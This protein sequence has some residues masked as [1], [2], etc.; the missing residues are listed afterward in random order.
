[1]SLTG[2]ALVWCRMRPIK[3][4]QIG[5]VG[6]LG[7]G[8][9]GNVG[10][11]MTKVCWLSM[12]LGLGALLV[13]CR[14]STSAPS[15]VG[16]SPVGAAASG[17]T[18]NVSGTV[19][20]HTVI[21]KRPLA[22]LH[23]TVGFVNRMQVDVVSD[24]NGH[25]EAAGFPDGISIFLRV[26]PEQG[27]RAPCPAPIVLLKSNTLLDLDVVSN[28]TLL[29]SGVPASLPTPN[30]LPHVLGTVFEIASGSL[31]PVGGAEVSLLDGYSSTLS[32][33]D[34][35]YLVCLP[36]DNEIAPTLRAVKDGYQPNVQSVVL[37]TWNQRLD[38]ELRQ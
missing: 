4:H 6:S 24:A 8:V 26:S 36:W 3:G 29:A 23:V 32:G 5:N 19:F 9:L 13:A 35:R 28:D 14:G 20:E 33:P 25:Y 10:P 27:Y 15:G 16:S 31:S 2:S 22:G 1:M 7:I 11:A 37:S 30:N 12:T 17:R 21:Q 34:G 18:F 38:F